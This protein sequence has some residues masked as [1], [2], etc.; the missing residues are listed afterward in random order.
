MEPASAAITRYN[1]EWLA[2]IDAAMAGFTEA[3]DNIAERMVTGEKNPLIEKKK[4][5][6]RREDYNEILV[7]ILESFEKKYQEDNHL[8]DEEMTAL[9]ELRTLG[10]DGNGFFDEMLRELVREGVVTQEMLAQ[11]EGSIT[12][13]KE[14][15]S[16]W[17]DEYGPYMIFPDVVVDGIKIPL[18][19]AFINLLFLGPLWTQIKIQIKKIVARYVTKACTGMLAEI[20]GRSNEDV[21]QHIAG[22]VEQV[23]DRL[24]DP[25]LQLDH[26][27]NPFK[28]SE[29]N[30]AEFKEYMDKLP[31]DMNTKDE[32][33]QFAA[34][35]NTMTMFFLILMGPDYYSDF[36]NQVS[37]VNQTSYKKN[38]ARLE[39]SSIKVTVKTSDLFLSGTTDNIYVNVYRMAEGKKVLYARQLMDISG[40]DDFEA[41]DTREYIVELPRSVKLSE[42]EIGLSKTPAFGFIPALTDDWHCENIEIMPMYAGYDLFN[43]AV[44]LGG[45]QLK[46]I[47]EGI[48]MNFQAAL[49]AGREAANQKTQTV[50]NLKVE[51]KVKNELWA[52]T[53]SD[54]YV[55]AYNGNQ[56]WAKVCLDKAMYNDLEQNDNDTYMIPITAVKATAQGIPLN[57]LSIKIVHEGDDQ[58]TW[59]SVTITPCYGDMELTDPVAGGGGKFEN[60][61]WRTTF[62]SN[63]KKTTYKQYEPYVLEYETI[64][65][66]GLVS[67]MGS[68]DGG[69]EWVDSDNELWA[70]TTLRKDVFFKIFR[71]FAPE[72]EYTGVEAALQCDP[73]PIVME[74]K[75]M[76]NGVSNERR[77][78]VKDLEHVYP[79]E[80]TAK[81]EFHNENGDLVH[82]ETDVDVGNGSILHIMNPGT[83]PAGLYD[84]TVYYSPDEANPLFSEAKEC[85]EDALQIIAAE[86]FE[87]KKH[88]GSEMVDPDTWVYFTV[89]AVGGLPPYNYDWEYYYAG[90]WHQVTNNSTD[91]AGQ[92]TNKLSAV[93]KINGANRVRCTISDS[94]GKSQTSNVANLIAVGDLSVTIDN[95]ETRIQY[96]QKDNEPRAL[97]ANLIG[98]LAPYTYTWYIKGFGASAQWE[99]VGSGSQFTITPDFPWNDCYIKV[100][101][102]DS[103]GKTAE[104]QILRID[105]FENIN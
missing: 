43:E 16:Y 4:E 1:D 60:T 103:I 81:I 24:E 37:G 10:V 35:Q 98:G 55:A 11:S 95:G 73:V 17:W 79:V 67:Y 42:M 84:L 2:D 100:V 21:A 48:G 8:S 28:P 56:L 64:L 45:V 57:D 6:E 105:Y 47:C 32:E 68:L 104:S 53:D 80:G 59:D 7:R 52:G 54:V 78:Q 92:G 94:S 46:G 26:P 20:T 38:T 77:G 41:N 27:D 102:R 85:F 3:C 72:I 34:L 69:E 83:L 70:N 58:A 39:A 25:E 9:K 89:E 87:I 12:I 74:L 15:I 71:G 91:F 61:T 97:T 33:T 96:Y 22:I 36:V 31:L 88:P 86:K 66:G 19:G 82:T 101:V 49:K 62:Q 14:E 23:D 99:E 76:W 51:V 44:D 18:L 29:D 93:A 90:A 63:L 5:E 50:T 30:F 75:G 40:E 13:I 65:D